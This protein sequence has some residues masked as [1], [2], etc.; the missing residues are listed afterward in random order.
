MTVR[1]MV[2]AMQT[3]I[4]ETDVQPDRATELLDQ[5]SA[6]V[7]NVND[8]IRVADQEYAVVLL[9][10]LD[11]E[12][13]ANR[14]KIRAETTPEYLRKREARDTKELVLALIGSMKYFLNAKREEMKLAR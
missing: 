11:S 13:K 6:L 4:R 12:A 9:Q 2:K 7:G 14:A 1:E 8:E 5:L 10:C 3:E